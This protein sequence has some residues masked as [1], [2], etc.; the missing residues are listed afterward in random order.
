MSN[1]TFSQK[2]QVELLKLL[3]RQLPIGL[4]AE[5]LA[6]I[7]LVVGLW[8]VL[9]NGL[10]LAW[11]L[12]NLLC[13]GVARH[14]L[15]AWFNRSRLKQYSEYQHYQRWMV[16]FAVGV[17]VSAVNWGLVGSLLLVQGDE[18]RRTFE[19][20]ILV[21]VTAGCSPFYS[22]SRYMYS[23]FIIP[24]FIPFAITMMLQGGVFYVLGLIS[25]V[26]VAIMIG[27]SFYSYQL[28]STSL[29][30]RFKNS[31]LVNNLEMQKNELEKSLSLIKATLESATDGI[32]AVDSNNKVEDYNQKFVD[33]WHLHQAVLHGR[34]T[35]SLADMMKHQLKDPASFLRKIEELYANKEQDSF[36]ELYFIN[37]MVFERYSYPQRLDDK[38]VGR[39]WSFR[40]VTERKQLEDKLMYQ[41]NYDSITGLPNRNFLLTYISREMVIAKNN[42]TM[43]AVLFVD[44]DG[45]KYIN[46][47]F[48]HTLGDKVLKTISERLQSCLGSGDIISRGSS[49]EFIIVLPALTNE[50]QAMEK[51]NQF[52]EITRKPFTINGSK[53]TVTISIGVNYFPQDAEDPETL[54]RNADISM[55]RAKELGKNGVQFFSEEMNRKISNRLVIE[56]NLIDALDKNEFFLVYQP[57]VNIKTG[58]VTGVEAL[59]RWIQPQLGL[60][61]PVNFIPVA[62]A[63]GIILPIGEWVMR[64]AC[65]QAKKWQMAG[66][67]SLQMSVN[68]SSKQFKQPN[69][70]ENISNIIAE[71]AFDPHLLS[72]ELTESTIMDDIEKNIDL[73]K[74]LK[75]I[76]V[77]ISIDDFGVGYSSLNYLKQ[78]PVDKLKIDRSFI[79]DIPIDQD[80]MAI[81]SAIIAMGST[82]GLKILAE[83]VES[84]EQLDFLKKLNC[85]EIQGYYFSRP[86]EA[87]ECTKL[88]L[89]KSVTL[90]SK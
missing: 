69:L 64:N 60:I 9:D 15:V 78:L 3:Y 32:L 41:A 51:A 25:L 38:Y 57:I 5:S 26:Y 71:T 44:V 80:D 12:M 4:F 37:G 61:M 75:K 68:L 56:N 63:S 14:I 11:L 8:G 49:D 43:M 89:D 1:E 82:L 39:V 79:K 76:G 59:I 62:E 18:L 42:Q 24:A 48:G 40:N 23:L 54:I 20:I 67:S 66:V 77:S 45:F 46:D 88:L 22:P 58:V 31:N 7:S 21:G 86:L 87:D 72:I 47:T 10:L 50:I 73:L 16:L 27:V 6:A 30:L 52:L 28:I 29:A 19:I 81:T 65:L 17:F 33:M 55:Y 2:I 36:D 85:D 84:R 90:D 13:C 70:L 35:S 34:T 74:Q 53:F 83:G